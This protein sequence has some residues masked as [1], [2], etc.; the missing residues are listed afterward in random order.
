VMYQIILGN[1]PIFYLKV[2]G[3]DYM[4]VDGMTYLM[5]GGDTPLKING[6]YLLG[7][8]TFSGEVEDE[9]GYT[10]AVEV[11]ITFKSLPHANEQT[12]TTAE[13]TPLPIMLTADDLYP[14]MLTWE[15]VDQPQHGTLTGTAPDVTYTPA[16]N[17]F[18]P[19]SFTF[20]V[21]DGS[22]YSNTAMVSITVTPVNDSPVA[23]DDFYSVDEDTTLVVAA[24]GVLANDIEVDP[25]G[26]AAV[27]FTA[28]A[29]GLLTL[30]EDGSFTY[31]PDKDFNG[32]DT[33][34][35][36]MVTY[37]MK[38]WVD[39]AVVTITV[40]PVNDDPVADVIADV[41]WLAREAHTYDVSGSFSDVDGD[42]LTFS[43]ELEGSL[44]LPS[45][46]SFDSDTGVFSGTPTNNVV[47][48]YPIVVT[49][50]DGNGGQVTSTFTLTV[51]LNPYRVFVPFII[52]P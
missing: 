37:P 11:D 4:L 12:L 52:N 13:D 15:I 30:L 21:Y 32:I 41:E 47:G 39:D 48:V 28:P 33:F 5:G 25:D 23:V 51:I 2:T 1:Q 45:W 17:Y 9:F 34:V 46:L 38:S 44:P 49:A 14:D 42:T 7:A 31:I 6:D 10:D 43:A 19:D 50:D 20:R 16:L 22:V 40:N 24:P 8:Y 29:H 36:R 26:I 3:T 18:G 35:Y 27:L